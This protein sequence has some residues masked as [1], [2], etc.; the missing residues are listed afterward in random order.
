MTQGPQSIG[1]GPSGIGGS[2]GGGGGVTQAQVTTS[3]NNAITSTSIYRDNV[4]VGIAPSAAEFASPNTGDVATVWLSNGNSEVWEYSGTAWA[5]KL[6]VSPAINRVRAILDQGNLANATMT[7]TV[8][9]NG[10]SEG[11]TITDSTTS[12]AGR[13]DAIP[14]TI[15]ELDSRVVKIVMAKETGETHACRFAIRGPVVNSWVQFEPSTGEF[16]TGGTLS[17]LHGVPSMVVFDTGESWTLY[18][19]F[20]DSP[21][22]EVVS[23]EISPAIALANG[24]GTEAPAGNVTGSITIYSLDLHAEPVPGLPTFIR[25]QYQEGVIYSPLLDPPEY[26][27]TSRGFSP[28]T[29]T[30]SGTVPLT[31]T[32]PDV[33]SRGMLGAVGNGNVAVSFSGSTTYLAPMTGALNG[34]TNFCVLMAV[35]IDDLATQQDVFRL[36][37]QVILRIRTDGNLQAYINTNNQW[38]SDWSLSL[39]TGWGLIGLEFANDTVTARVNGTAGTG[40]SAGGFGIS[41]ANTSANASIGSHGVGGYFSGLIGETILTVQQ[42]THEHLLRLEGYLAWLYGIA[43]VLP[44]DHPYKYTRP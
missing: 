30:N 42:C 7:N 18:I 8:G 5:R 19:E 41:N 9:A 15:G 13:V 22:E 40:S 20:F 36:R 37:E 35:R 43:D 6:S 17:Q 26:W 23:L 2:G 27:F 1:T 25:R 29:I 12:A 4:A 10:T 11:V 33:A 16:G 32:A 3:I 38:R 21:S 28:E 14:F 24:S 31:L 34:V 44:F 39:S